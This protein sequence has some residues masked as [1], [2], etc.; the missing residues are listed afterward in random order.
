MRVKDSGSVDWDL[1]F[2]VEGLRVRVKAFETWAN[3]RAVGV[4]AVY[5]L[6]RNQD[7]FG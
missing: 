1:G 5:V 7:I 4:A 2:R 6:E 3:I